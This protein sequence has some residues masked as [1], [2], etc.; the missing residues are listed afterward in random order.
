M[1]KILREV[2]YS[3]PN[4]IVHFF[5]T[6]LKPKSYPYS[7]LSQYESETEIKLGRALGFAFVSFLLVTLINYV[8]LNNE[9]EAVYP[10]IFLLSARLL[11][12]IV[13][14]SF[15]I[16]LGW[17]IVGSKASYFNYLIIY[18]YHVGVV[19]VVFFLVNSVSDGLLNQLEPDLYKQILEFQEAKKKDPNTPFEIDNLWQNQNYLICMIILGAGN[20][21][22]FIWTYVGYGAYRKM[23]QAS[24]GRTLL[25]LFIV[26]IL[27]WVG[28]GLIWILDKS[29]FTSL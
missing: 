6:F 3:I 22:M 23:N 18:C 14:L 25:S 20:L 21:T 11:V 2:F 4:Y 5:K 26:G 15:M 8:R 17:A 9:L 19:T 10:E 29:I 28:I 13:I 27:T 7:Q 16:Y 24:F 12:F 1:E